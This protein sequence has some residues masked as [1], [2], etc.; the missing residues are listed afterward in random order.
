[1]DDTEQIIEN[2]LDELRRVAWE[3]DEREHIMGKLHLAIRSMCNLVDDKAKREAY[4]A[5]LERYK[6]HTGLTDLI[7]TA[8]HMAH[9]PLTPREIRDFIVN[10]GSEVSTQQNILQSIHTI[11]RRMEESK[12]VISKPNEDGEK[13]YKIPS[14]GE[15]ILRMDRSIEPANANRVGKQIETRFAP[16]SGLY[17]QMYGTSKDK[18]K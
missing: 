2:K 15:R 13:T 9:K 18:K 14:L 3:R 16:Q 10:Y 7:E 5:V 1:M 17:S 8:M 12:N 6:V 4:K 11:L